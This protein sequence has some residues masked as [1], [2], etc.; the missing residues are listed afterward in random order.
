MI[1]AS[2]P[3]DAL[4]RLSLALALTLG[5]LVLFAL[6]AGVTA[7]AGLFGAKAPAVLLGLALGPPLAVAVLAV[8]V[9]G[10]LL[11]LA[12]FPAGATEVPTPVVSLQTVELAVLVVAGL[13]GAARVA[14]RYERAVWSPPLW[15]AAALTAWTL[16][17]V[18]SAIDTGLATKQ[19]ASLI[20]GLVFAVVLLAACEDMT[21]ARRVLGG[22]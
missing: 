9:L 6:G 13:V 4:R 5:A 3:A 15:W 22:R 8:P 2:R 17:L 20:G 16:V 12:T 10:P 11:V 21:D 18:P 1:A 19:L 14:G 7:V